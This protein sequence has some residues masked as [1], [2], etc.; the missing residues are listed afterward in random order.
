VE[1]VADALMKLLLGNYNGSSMVF[2]KDGIQAFDEKERIEKFIANM[3]DS[4]DSN[5]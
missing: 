3:F 1:Q 2:T 4:K 5:E